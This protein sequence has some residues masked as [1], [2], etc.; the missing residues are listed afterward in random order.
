MA[1]ILAIE[2]DKRQAA[3]LKVLVKNRLHA[4][5]VLADTTELA[6][7]AIGNRIPDLVL[8]PALLSPEEDGALNAALR[9]IAAAA[10]VQTL[11]I[12]VFA[13]S[14]TKKAP[15]K[16]GGLLS[17]LLAGKNETAPE[18][19]DPAV[20]GDQIAAYLA[21]V[22][23][24]RQSDEDDFDDEPPA[25]PKQTFTRVE[26]F[27]QPETFQ[28]AVEE[29]EAAAAVEDEIAEPAVIEESPIEEPAVEASPVDE[30]PAEEPP[31]EEPTYRP[32]EP[33]LSIL[34]DPDAAPNPE[35]ARRSFGLDSLLKPRARK[36][37]APPPASEWPAYEP[38]AAEEA[39]PEAAPDDDNDWA[40]K[41][42]QSIAIDLP[43][44]DDPPT[45]RAVEPVLE[46][47]TSTDGDT[48][49]DEDAAI[50]PEPPEPPMTPIALRRQKPWPKF[51]APPP[52]PAPPDLLEEF[53]A[54]LAARP[55]PS[56]ALRP[57][58]QKPKSTPAAP[59]PKPPAPAPAPPPMAAKP[60]AAREA[61]TVKAKAPS[62]PSPLKAKSERPE[63]TALIDSLRQDME[64]MRQDRGDRAKPAVA[65]PAP[66]VVARR[67]P[68]APVARREA[69]VPVARREPPPPVARRE[70]A[71][72][73]A[74][75]PARPAKVVAQ[76]DQT[77][78]RKKRPQQPVPVQ[79][80]WG[81]FDPQQCGFAALLAKL[82][83]ITEN[84]ESKVP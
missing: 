59:A 83:E 21:D 43:A 81:F 7:E 46:E 71:P 61:A 26:T 1:L 44:P 31:A 20:F 57:T 5:L 58:P 13:P 25:L 56:A 63:W 10:H 75:A 51:D 16:S 28:A 29:L 38:A 12:P 4:D 34:R 52:V 84:E 53:T 24:S 82:D 19:C 39:A 79:D 70:E 32:A 27:A 50:E 3:Q 11:T 66:V 80:E 18:G 72:P 73:V 2:P 15:A 55:K 74:A 22:A 48:A 30:L 17:K 60:I 67:E 36:P 78:K 33:P 49:V 35:P 64:R 42:D 54:D 37:L 76:E 23:A 41:K 14:H 45:Y 68:P 47:E 65:P 69:P 62:A 6:L 8:V 9:V 40:P 77:I